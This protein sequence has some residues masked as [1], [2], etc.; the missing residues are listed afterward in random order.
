MIYEVSVLVLTII[1]SL[2]GIQLVIVLHNTK[3]LLTE[4]RQAAKSVNKSLPVI[5]SDV[6]STVEEVENL[7]KTAREC[8]DLFAGRFLGPLCSITG[9]LNAFKVAYTIMRRKS[10]EAAKKDSDEQEPDYGE[11]DLREQNTTE[12]V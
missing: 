6:E 2:V 3:G 1:L 9:F 12:S 11:A 7:T 8:V 5:L 4:L 10:R